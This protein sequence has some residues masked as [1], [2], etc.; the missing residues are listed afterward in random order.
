MKIAALYARVSGEQQRDSNT[1]ASQTEAL[2]AHAERH[3]YHAAPDMVIEDDGF[4]GAVL[5][6]PGLERVRDLAA[7][8]RIEAV[9]VHAPDRLSR[10]YA[11]Q[12]LIIEELARQDVET[13]FLNAP[14]MET[15]EDHLL[16]QFQGMIAEYERAQILER[17]RHGKRHR[18]RRGDV[19]VLSGAPF[20][21][22]YHRKTQ[23]SDAFYEIVEP[24]ASVVRDVC[25]HYTEDHMTIGAI[26]RKLNKR[27]VSTSSGRSLRERSVVWAMLRNPAYKGRAC[28]GKARSAPR[29]RVR[30][31]RGSD[32]FS[33]RNSV[34]HERPRE[35]WIEIPLPAIVSEETFA[36]AEERLQQNKA[37]SKR[38]TRTPSI[39][40]GLV[41][42]GKCGFSLYRRSVRT[43]AQGLQLPLPG[44]RRLAPSQRPAVRQPTRTP[45]PARRHRVDRAGPPAR[46]S[47]S[48]AG[49]DRPAPG[50]GPCLRSQPEARGR[51]SASPGQGPQGHRPAGHGL[52]GRVDHD[53][54][55]A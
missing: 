27:G 53:R 52:S 42:C 55:A 13:V 40:Q 43:S 39:S 26:A 48:G 35:D 15:H 10:R 44:F 18:A 45:G 14:S 25:R 21:Y 6:R 28:F 17:S 11:C 19:A 33:G 41:A 32:G 20:G 12:V 50:G 38:R 47:G 5:E 36:L 51:P 3:G 31:L 8:G 4:S 24:Q 23:D 30:P 49:R 1:I 29:Q 2:L 54:R 9:P 7:E 46:G 37:F 22:R 34:G 16:L